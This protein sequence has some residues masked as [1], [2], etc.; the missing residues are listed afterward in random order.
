VVYPLSSTWTAKHR[1]WLSRQ[2]FDE[3]VSGLVFAESDGFARDQR[4]GLKRDH[5]VAG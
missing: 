1:V 5:R 4:D 2:Q 3:P